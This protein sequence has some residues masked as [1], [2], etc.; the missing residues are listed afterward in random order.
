MSIPA[1]LARF[2]QQILV[3][4]LV[5][6]AILLFAQDKSWYQSS[7]REAKTLKHALPYPTC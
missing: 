7:N 2:S 6:T 5:Y 1:M 3:V 4:E